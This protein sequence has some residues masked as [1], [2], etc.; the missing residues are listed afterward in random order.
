MLPRYRLYTN[1]L[2]KSCVS[3]CVYMLAPNRCNSSSPPMVTVKMELLFWQKVCHFSCMSEI[4][5]AGIGEWW[6][7]KYSGCTTSNHI[8]LVSGTGMRPRSLLSIFWYKEGLQYG[9]PQETFLRNLVQVEITG[10]YQPLLP[11][12]A[13]I[14]FVILFQCKL[15]LVQHH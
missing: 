4:N 11:M 15:I 2:R 10:D 12:Y 8:W 1:L 5:D 13:R 7:E 14:H 3:N 6:R 9:S